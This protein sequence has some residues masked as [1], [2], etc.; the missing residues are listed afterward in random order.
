MS[1]QKRPIYE[2][3]EDLF[4]RHYESYGED[5]YPFDRYEIAYTYGF[6]FMADEAYPEQKWSEIKQGMRR[7]WEEMEAGPWDDFKEAI[8]YAWHTAKDAMSE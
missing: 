5:R 2:D 6:N 7:G 4:H 8:R 1:E 3:H